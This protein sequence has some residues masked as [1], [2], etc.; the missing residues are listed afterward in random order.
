VKSLLPRLWLVPAQAL[1]ETVVAGTENVGSE[2]AVSR[3]ERNVRLKRHPG[4][5]TPRDLVVEELSC[6]G[7]APFSISSWLEVIVPLVVE[8]VVVLGL[9]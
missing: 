5:E 6:R 4:S 8:S 7:A 2:V 1:V 3:T 9:Y